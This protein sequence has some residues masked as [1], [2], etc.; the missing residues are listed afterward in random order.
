MIRY[1]TLLL[2]GSTLLCCGLPALMVT[3]GFGSSLVSLWSVF[4]VLLLLSEH[5][6][7]VWCLSGLFI[8]INGIILLKNRFRSCPADQELASSCRMGR[9]TGYRLWFLSISL[10]FV[11]V[12]LGNL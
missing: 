3:L 5:K 12:L 2:S 10:F 8:F 11:G 1:L 4:P 9:K 6:L 7:I